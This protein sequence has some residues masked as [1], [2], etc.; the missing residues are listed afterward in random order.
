MKE[1]L[2][3]IFLLFAALNS[4]H[5]GEEMVVGRQGTPWT[6]VREEAS[7]LSVDRDSIWIWDVEPEQN[8]APFVLQRGGR[9]F[10]VVETVDR[11]GQKSRGLVDAPGLEKILDGDE[12]TAFDPDRAG[13]PRRAELYIDLGG[14]FVVDEISFFPRLDSEH[15]RFYLQSFELGSN[16]TADEVG[17]DFREVIDLPFSLLINA[18]PFQP[19]DQSV[20]L[21][22]RPEESTEAMEMRHVRIK[23]LGDHPWEIAEVE[24][25]ATGR[26][27]TAEFVSRPLTVP[28][29]APVWGRLRYEGGDIDD[30]PIVV[31]TRTGPDTEPVHYFLRLTKSKSFRKVTKQG[32]ENIVTLSD[33]ERGEAEQGP[34]LPNP[35]WSAWETVSDGLILSPSPQEYIQFR[36]QMGEPGIKLEQFVFEYTSWPL[37]QVIE[38]EVDPVQAVAG[39]ETEFVL[40]MRVQRLEDNTI[41]TS[42]FRHLQVLTAA[43]ITGVDRVLVKDRE[44]FH[45]VRQQPGRGFSI[46]FWERVQADISF[47]QLFFRGRVFADGTSFRVQAIDER[48]TGDGVESIYQFARE[49]DVDPFTPG[50]SLSVR[51]SS[52]NS[53]LVGVLK[54]KTPVFT[55]NGDGINDFFELGYNLLKLTREAPVFFEIFDLSGR[56]VRQGYA[57]GDASGRFV[58]IWDG[59][60]RQGK[61]V[62]PGL[63]LYE[64]RVQA[65]A[66]VVGRQGGVNVVY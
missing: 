16:R 3:C 65:D 23:T 11:F 9:I 29:G 25:R 35:D 59:R 38:A 17:G 51:L 61:R 37:A 21:W 13:L 7:F 60:D 47:V 32:W 36:V 58:R 66:G 28:G 12:N 14:H 41:P 48:S 33:V 56:R 5:A 22:P 53:P 26:V 31:Q 54:P 43:E 27:R 1:R 2:L 46:E 44:V 49:G 34:I 10:A 4:V 39:E 63:Y 8:I 45:T 18:H 19:N 55:P 52:R 20:V 50:G 24:I 30:L 6:L 62:L 57:G 15:R 40:S 64:V 42:G